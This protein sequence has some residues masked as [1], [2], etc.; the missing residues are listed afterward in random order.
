MNIFRKA[1]AFLLAAVPSLPTSAAAPIV[2]SAPTGNDLRSH[3]K[4]SQKGKRKRARRNN[5]GRLKKS[6]A[7]SNR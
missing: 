7:K 6:T 2:L 3:N 1:M 4:L 5:Q